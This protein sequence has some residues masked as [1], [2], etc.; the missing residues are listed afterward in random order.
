M[1]DVGRPRVVRWYS[2]RRACGRW[3]RWWEAGRRLL[4]HVKTEA[5]AV[6]CVLAREM[7]VV[8]MVPEH[9]RARR[10]EW[11][12]CSQSCCYTAGRHFAT[13][14]RH[15]DEITQSVQ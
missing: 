3:K 11:N 8:G 14:T 10:L 5:C 15:L 13:G 7:G 1:L 12:M 9:Q 2:P 4:Q 6:Q